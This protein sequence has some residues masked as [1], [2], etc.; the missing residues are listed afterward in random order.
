[1][2]PMSL[3]SRPG[4]VSDRPGNTAKRISKIMY[5]VT[6]FGEDGHPLPYFPSW[7]QETHPFH[8]EEGRLR[9]PVKNA[10]CLT[11]PSRH[12]QMPGGAKARRQSLEAMQ[13]IMDQGRRAPHLRLPDSAVSVTVTAIGGIPPHGMMHGRWKI[14][15]LPHDAATLSLPEDWRINEQLR[16]YLSDHDVSPE[17]ANEIEAAVLG[18]A[19]QPWQMD[20]YWPHQDWWYEWQY[21][22]ESKASVVP[23]CLYAHWKEQPPF[24]SGS[25]ELAIMTLAL[26]G[27]WLATKTGA[28]KLPEG[29]TI[30]TCGV[31]TQYVNAR[32]VSAQSM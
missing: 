13:A 27:R 2:K 32:L 24:D 15:P 6:I 18:Y 21:A 16:E 28:E 5:A 12:W 29:L 10:R 31:E 11:Q 4:R 19:L 8:I 14:E 23:E 30:H 9:G 7:R 20:L 3:S 25:W 22:S 1:M 17:Q 26:A